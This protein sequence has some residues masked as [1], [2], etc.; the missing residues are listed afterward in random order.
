[1]DARGRLNLAPSSFFNAVC[2]NPPTLMFCPGVRPSG[3]PKDTWRNIQSR[4]PG[5]EF[6]FDF[7]SQCRPRRSTYPACRAVLAARAQN[8]DSERAMISAIQQAYYLNARN[9]SDDEVLIDLARH[10][11]LDTDRFENDLNSVETRTSLLGE[12]NFGQQLGAHGFP[13]MVLNSNGASSLLQLDYNSA[14]NIIRQI[15]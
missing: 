12:I 5:T 6:N 11:Q 13:S 7:W 3:E 2:A 4:I 1:M 15:M 9:P 10:L 14:E 8:P